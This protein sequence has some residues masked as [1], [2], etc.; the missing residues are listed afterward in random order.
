MGVITYLC[1]PKKGP[2]SSPHDRDV[3]FEKS[4]GL[5]TVVAFWEN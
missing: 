2:L 3:S 4:G 1:E 5:P